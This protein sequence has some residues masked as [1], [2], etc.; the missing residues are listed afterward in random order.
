V[1]DYRMVYGDESQVVREVLE[2]VVLER[3]DG[4]LTFFRGDDAVLRVQEG[5]VQSLEVL[6]APGA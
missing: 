2:N 4:W 5:H 1:T 6:G 3:E